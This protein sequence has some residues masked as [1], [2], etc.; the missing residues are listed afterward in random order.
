MDSMH[1]DY[2]LLIPDG[3]LCNILLHV[4]LCQPLHALHSAPSLILDK[5][6]HQ[7]ADDRCLISLARVCTGNFDLRELRIT[8]CHKISSQGLQAFFKTTRT[9]INLEVVCFNCCG[10]MVNDETLQSIQA[11]APS[12]QHLEL[13]WAH[14]VTSAGVLHVSSQLTVLNVHGCESIDDAMCS[15]LPLIEV[16]GL[17]YTRVTAKGLIM[18]AENCPALRRLLCAQRSNNNFTS[19]CISEDGEEHF[20]RLRPEVSIEVV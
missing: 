14:R 11:C 20:K 1:E 16:L 19:S 12:L 7:W 10:D 2:F 6:C 18:L 13:M 5:G 15:G 9:L 17:G 4:T 3:V 8:F